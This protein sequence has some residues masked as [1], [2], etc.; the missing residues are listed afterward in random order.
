M[1]GVFITFEGPEGGGKSTQAARLA[2]RLRSS[3]IDVVTTR[4]PGGT[5]TGEAIRDIL[6]NDS[7]GEPICPETEVLLFAGSRAQLVRS[8]ILPALTRGA[9]VISDRFADSTTAYQGYGRGFPLAT[10]LAINAFA[11]GGAVPDLTFLLDV[12]VPTGFARLAKRNQKVGQ[13]HDRMEREDR[14]FHTRV[15]DGYVDLAGKCPERFRLLDGRRSEDDVHA[16]V[17][18]E[19]APRLPR[20]IA[21]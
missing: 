5:R 9:W 7:A 1:K 19:V 12:D 10:I 8:V 13:S 14:A 17:W 4:E 11:I 6:Q 3:G 21:G 20:P 16:E 15:R 2:A 18:R